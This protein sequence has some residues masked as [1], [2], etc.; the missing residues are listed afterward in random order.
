MGARR[1]QQRPVSLLWASNHLEKHDSQEGNRRHP[2]DLVN[3]LYTGYMRSRSPRAS[4]AFSEG[5][6]RRG[7]REPTNLPLY[8]AKRF[9]FGCAE[10]SPPARCP[11]YVRLHGT[12]AYPTLAASISGPGGRV[13]LHATYLSPCLCP[14][15]CYPLA[16][17]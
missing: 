14:P 12:L 5:R 13:R 3:T 16:Y 17:L 2:S 8:G 6:N 7:R 11:P 9:D 10:I 4:H 1:L 15:A